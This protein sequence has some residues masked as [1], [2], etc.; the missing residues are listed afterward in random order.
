MTPT[1]KE[2]LKFIFDFTNLTFAGFRYK[3]LKPCGFSE[4]QINKLRK[5][6]KVK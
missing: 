5:E 4:K 3:V 6:W 1:M 2:N